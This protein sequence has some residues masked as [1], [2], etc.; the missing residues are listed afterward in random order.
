MTRFKEGVCVVID[1]YNKVYE[2]ETENGDG[3]VAISV[4]GMNEVN[5]VIALYGIDTIRYATDKE[6]STGFK[7]VD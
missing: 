3:F 1:G 5:E 7:E 6:E 4:D 2:V